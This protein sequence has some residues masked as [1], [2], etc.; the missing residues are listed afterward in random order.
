MQLSELDIAP[1][2]DV[3]FL[4][5]HLLAQMHRAGTI[6]E[7]FTPKKFILFVPLGLWKLVGQRSIRQIDL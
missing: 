5:G 4:L 2:L 7:E 1:H 6:K 3:T